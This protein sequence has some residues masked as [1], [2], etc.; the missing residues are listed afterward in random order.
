MSLNLPPP[1]DICYQLDPVGEK[2]SH[3]TAP[4]KSCAGLL[5]MRRALMAMLPGDE[6]V[7][8]A[9][10]VVRTEN[11]EQYEYIIR[12][13]LLTLGEATAVLEGK[14]PIPAFPVRRNTRHKKQ[15]PVTDLPLFK[16]Q[17]RALAIWRPV[18]ELPIWELGYYRE[19]SGQKAVPGVN[20]IT[21]NVLIVL[22]LPEIA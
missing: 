19:G 21:S 12:G 18:I 8:G 17:C 11:Y 7:M 2:G 6:E 5:K 22:T 13:N 15:K 3:V 16:P 10:Y 1:T 20:L 4:R 14:T 9:L